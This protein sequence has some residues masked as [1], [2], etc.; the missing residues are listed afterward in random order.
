MRRDD[1]RGGGQGREADEEAE[2]RLLSHRSALEAERH[3]TALA[4]L[5]LS[6][7]RGTRG[8]E[9]LLRREVRGGGGLQLAREMTQ[10]NGRSWEIVGDH[11]RSW[12]AMRDQGTRLQLARVDLP[13]L[14][15]LLLQELAL[16][17]LC[18]HLPG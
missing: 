10:D 14:L 7:A 16:G 11:G 12:E 15:E 3:H 5:Q 1:E 17:L 9:A 2:T 8:V 6:G 18:L 13:H 4:L